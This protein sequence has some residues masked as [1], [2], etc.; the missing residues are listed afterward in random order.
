VPIAT[1]FGGM[2]RS[3]VDPDRDFCSE[4]VS[5]VVLSEVAVRPSGI[6]RIV[7]YPAQVWIDDHEVHF[8]APTCSCMI[9]FRGQVAVAIWSGITKDGDTDLVSIQNPA[10]NQEPVTRLAPAFVVL[11]YFIDHA[12]GPLHI[13]GEFPLEWSIRDAPPFPVPS[14]TDDL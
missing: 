12:L 2:K 10:S 9:P 11:H 7:N 1:C 8:R 4:L 6:E 3:L 5:A 13:L 14:V